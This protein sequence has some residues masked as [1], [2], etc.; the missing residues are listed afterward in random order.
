MT[1]AVQPEAGAVAEHPEAAASVRDP[2]DE[3]IER[4]ARERR[5][6]RPPARELVV[7]EV[8]CEADRLDL[9]PVA[10]GR[11]DLLRVAPAPEVPVAPAHHP[12]RTLRGP[13]ETLALGNHVQPVR[14]AAAARV[15]LAAECEHHLRDCERAALGDAVERGEPAL[16]DGVVEAV[17]DALDH[18][19]RGGARPRRHARA[20][21][22][23]DRVLVVALGEEELRVRGTDGTDLRGPAPGQP[24]EQVLAQARV[25]AHRVALVAP[26]DRQVAGAQRGEAGRRVRMPNGLGAL[27]GDVVE[28]RGRDEELAVLGRELRQDLRGKVA[29][30]RVGFAAHA[31]DVLLDRHASKS[32]PATQPPVASTA[33]AGSMSARPA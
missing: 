11:R 5:L 6:D 30:Q 1:A 31:R 3:R 21:E 22:L 2:H 17:D 33:R 25:A 9:G 7:D 18:A 26:G 27:G 29:V 14:H 32:T 24:L 10:R 13:G 19:F 20:Q 28:D 23:L 12:G 16:G 15:V 4:T 8:Q